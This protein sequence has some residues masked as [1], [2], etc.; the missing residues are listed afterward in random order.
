MKSNTTEVLPSEELRSEKRIKLFRSDASF[1]VVLT[2]NTVV[3]ATHQPVF[4]LS[5]C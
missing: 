1:G 5:V 2:L 4:M 3:S